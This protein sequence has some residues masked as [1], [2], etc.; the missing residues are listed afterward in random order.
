M[1]GLEVAG[2]VLG[3]FPIALSVL[4]AYRD[5]ANSLGVFHKIRLEHKKWCD[6]LEY[7]QLVFKSHLRELLLPL[8]ADDDKIAELLAAPG[9]EC[10]KEQDIAKLLQIRLHD[11]YALYMRYLY[12]M[13]RALDEVNRELALGS[14]SILESLHSTV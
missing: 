3:A 11:S 1:S 13:R 8:V 9:A 4:G 6:D 2:I 14:A 10:W 5:A 7:H 12:G